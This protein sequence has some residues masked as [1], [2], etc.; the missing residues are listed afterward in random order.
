MAA[1]LDAALALARGQTGAGD[2]V[3]VIGGGS[4]YAA[5]IVRADRLYVTHVAASPDGDTHFPPIDPARVAGGLARGGA[6]RRQGQRRN[7]LRRLRTG[8]NCRLRLTGS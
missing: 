2:E 5:A 8:R 1:D 6:G 4:V 7:H 3:M